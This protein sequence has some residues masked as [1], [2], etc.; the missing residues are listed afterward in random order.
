MKDNRLS[1]GLGGHL[2]RHFENHMTPKMEI[3]AFIG[4]LD[5]KNPET[6][7]RITSIPQVLRERGY[8]MNL[9]AILDAIL[10]TKTPT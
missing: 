4:F 8:F 10:K 3:I 5:P 6:A 2:G 1:Y 9:A 7:A